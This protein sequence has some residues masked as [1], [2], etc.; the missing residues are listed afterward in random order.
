MIRDQCYTVSPD[1][2]KSGVV[3]VIANQRSC[4]MILSPYL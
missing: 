3:Q 4:T 1:S 2:M